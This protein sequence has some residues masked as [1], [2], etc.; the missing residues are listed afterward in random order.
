MN[1][2]YY[3]LSDWDNQ[4]IPHSPEWPVSGR[5][6]VADWDPSPDAQGGGILGYLQEPAVDPLPALLERNPTETQLMPATS[7]WV[8][9]GSNE[10]VRLE[11]EIVK[12]P[13]GVALFCGNRSSA[14]EFVELI[15]T[16]NVRCEYLGDQGRLKYMMIGAEGTS[17]AVGPHSLVVGAGRTEIKGGDR[18]TL[19]GGRHARIEGGN[20]SIISGGKGAKVIVGNKAT[21]AGSDHAEVAAGHSCTVVGGY[22]STVV[23]GTLS[24]VVGGYKSTVRGGYGATV[25][26]GDKAMVIGGDYA[27]VI[28]GDDSLVQGG[29]NAQVFGGVN[30]KVCGGLDATLRIAYLDGEGKRCIS[31]A[32]IGRFGILADV[33]YSFDGTEWCVE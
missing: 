2:K 22:K 14:L 17:I 23:A 25:V 3:L 6:E 31:T 11:N 12:C 27:T 28:G 18:N 10:I 29:K 4:P 21:V 7:Q 20:H 16:K 30:A 5:V 33:V 24:T 1:Y 15:H 8:V 26:G 32:Y 9:L 13:W 19:I